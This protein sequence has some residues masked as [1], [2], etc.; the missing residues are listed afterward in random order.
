MKLSDRIQLLEEKLNL[1]I[2]NHLKHIDDRIK[3]TEWL[4]WSMFVLLL[5]IAWNVM[6]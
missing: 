4:Q 1:L 2:N 3:R 6:F 5:G